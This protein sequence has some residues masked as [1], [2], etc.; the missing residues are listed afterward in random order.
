MDAF[1][2]ELYRRYVSTYK[3][4]GDP[5]LE[6]WLAKW[7]ETRY[8]PWLSPVVRHD[9]V[10]EIGCGSGRLL[11]QLKAHGFSNVEGIDVSQE[12]VDAARRRGTNVMCGD[13]FDVLD[14]TS[15]A[16]GAIVA[17]DVVEHFT[18]SELLRLLT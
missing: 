9:R 13:V 14:H 8:L 11:D 16:F 3:G 6:A 1:R 2:S 17:I 15:A 7:C 5:G 18:K 12:Q 4:A 10:L